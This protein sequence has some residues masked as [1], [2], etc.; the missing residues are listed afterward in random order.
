MDQARL[1]RYEIIAQLATGGMGR[2]S[3]GKSSGE[4]GFE[5]HVVIK[6]LDAVDIDDVEA[7]AMF[8]T[9]VVTVRRRSRVHAEDS[10]RDQLRRLGA[11]RTKTREV[12]RRSIECT[13]RRCALSIA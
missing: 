6:S 8:L 4:G 12:R 13:H 5:R 3:L 7:T 9:F 10:D 11:D 2:V 1:G